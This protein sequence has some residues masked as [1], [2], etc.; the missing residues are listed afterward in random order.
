MP[1]YVQGSVLEPAAGTDFLLAVS[2]SDSFKLLSLIGTLTSGADGGQEA[3]T[4]Q[5]V[6]PSGEVFAL[7]VTATT[8][9]ASLP[10]TYS[11]VAKTAWV[12]VA[13]YGAGA[14]ANAILPD[15]WLPAGTTIMSHTAEL[16]TDDQWSDI[17][18]TALVGDEFEH[19]QKLDRLAHQLEALIALSSQGV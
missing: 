2:N 6:T 13:A 15:L 4:L 10:A 7:V 11:W 16:Q 5:L 1:K 18:Y 19:L 17:Y 12:S 14:A 3:P 8:A 9:A